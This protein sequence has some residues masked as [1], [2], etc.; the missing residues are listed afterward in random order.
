MEEKRYWEL[1]HKNGDKEPEEPPE[2]KALRRIDT[3]QMTL[4]LLIEVCKKLEI[5]SDT[6]LIPFMKTDS[7][8]RKEHSF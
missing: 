2:K 1:F 5:N 7:E 4:A 8:I 3:N 6:I